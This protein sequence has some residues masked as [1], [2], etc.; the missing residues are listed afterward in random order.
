[1]KGLPAVRSLAAWLER[2]SA[3]LR[4]LNLPGSFFHDEPA[5]AAIPACLAAAAQLEE[6]SFGS[7]SLDSTEWLAALCS[8][9]RL[10]LSTGQFDESL[11]IAPAINALT[12]LETLRL[13]G[14]FKLGAGA[15][16]PAGL[17]RLMLSCQDPP[18]EEEVSG[19]VRLRCSVLRELLAAL[20]RCTWPLHLAAALVHGPM[21]LLTDSKHSPPPLMPRLRSAP[22]CS[23]RL[24]S[25][26]GWPGLS[27][28]PLDTTQ[29]SSQTC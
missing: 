2:H 9:R 20:G 8:L 10:E 13:G 28:S 19:G 1:M 22:A 27:S 4:R 29:A 21:C 16:L 5:L 7:R 26:L 25:C 11:H 14:N 24:P 17:T 3:H 12:A 6:L 18:D 15:R 23:P